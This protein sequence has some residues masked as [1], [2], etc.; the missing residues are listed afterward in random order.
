MEFLW[1]AFKQAISLIVHR[2]H[3]LMEIAEVTLKVAFVSTLTALVIGLPIGLALGLGRFRGR[4]ATLSLFNAGLGLPPVVVGIFLT[5]LLF[6]RGPLW[7]TRWYDT[8]NGV[9]LAQTILALPIVVAL[10]A[11]AVLNVPAGLLDQARAF[12]A[13]RLPVAALALREA[14]IGVFAAAIAAVGA[15]LSEVGAVVLVGGNI[16]G[17]TQTLAAAVLDEVAGGDYVRAMA[18]GIVLLGMILLVA[19]GLT[20]AQ[21]PGARVRLRALT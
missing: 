5:L 21:Q 2:D 16:S 6:P 12:G 15:S 8:L 3:A 1:E 14:R 20:L 4:T 13:G 11:A 17:E 7:W 18:I 19:A 10:T 9:Y